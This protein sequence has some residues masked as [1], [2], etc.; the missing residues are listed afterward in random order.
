VTGRDV[1]LKFSRSGDTLM[2][3]EGNKQLLLLSY[4]ELRMVRAYPVE[5][6]VFNMSPDGRTAVF[7]R[8]NGTV[9]FLDLRT[10]RVRDADGRHTQA[11]QD[12][13][14][15]PDGRTVL[16]TGDDRNVLVW[17][18]AIRSLR[19]I[20]TGHAGRVFGPA[21]DS[22]G[23][24]AF[25]VGLDGR[26]IAWDLNGD[27]RIGRGFRYADEE[28][29][30]DREFVTAL[31]PD[32]SLLAYSGAGNRVVVQDARTQKPRWSADPWSDRRIEALRKRGF[33]LAE[34]RITRIAF[35]R[36]SRTVAVAGSNQEV[37]LFSAE[38]GQVTRRLYASE[39]GWVNDVSFAGDGRLVTAGDDGTAIVWNPA[40]GRAQ[41]TFRLFPRASSIDDWTGGVSRAVVSPDGGRLATTVYGPTTKSELSVY[42]LS[43]RRLIWREVADRWQA[44]A[45]WS[46]D[47]RTIATGGRQ[48]GHLTL[49]DAATGRRIGE[50]V[51]A[52]SGFVNSIGFARAGTVVVT[53][54][55]DG[56]MRLYDA[57]TLKQV[58]ANVVARENSDTYAHVLPGGDA[59]MVLGRGLGWTWQLDPD[60]WAA[61]ACLVAN[62]Q[63]SRSERESF[64]P[65]RER[66][67]ACA[68]T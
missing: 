64:L 48:S 10:G 31:S 8:Q 18:V 42:D 28:A 35:S 40:T 47:G 24:T 65:G 43:N 14:Y 27:R 41:R 55:T 12:I 50:P 62:R 29:V 59:V 19:E 52:N 32:G 16:S 23:K 57:A 38:S 6:F 21:F 13:G 49:R 67:P 68:K 51:R 30:S 53:A 61:Q 63:L 25:T 34:G 2:V 15:S 26:V 11:V 44:E 54:G 20:L 37:V 4:P 5:P 17:D 33:D 9:A 45:A 1:S 7:G 39:I 3:M 60:R 66:E 22:E 56:T 36:D 46:P 58:G